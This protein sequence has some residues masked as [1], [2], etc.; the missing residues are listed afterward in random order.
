M[1]LVWQSTGGINLVLAPGLS[2]I[3]IAVT[4]IKKEVLTV[5]NSQIFFAIN[6]VN[7]IASLAKATSTTNAMQK[8]NPNKFMRECEEKELAKTIIIKQVQDSMQEL[9]QEVEEV[10]W[11]GRYSEW[12]RRP[13]KVRMRSQVVVGIREI[14]ILE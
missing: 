10:I 5:H 7:C 2:L 8:E 14:N 6:N 13:M 9:D 11:L 3:P 1:I 4:K 12:G